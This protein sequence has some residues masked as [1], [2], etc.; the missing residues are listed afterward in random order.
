MALEEGDVE[1]AMGI[2]NT[3]AATG[4]ARAQF[5]YATMLEKGLGGVEKDVVRARHTRTRTHTLT[6]TLV[7]ANDTW[8]LQRHSSP[9]LPHGTAP[10]MPVCIR[11]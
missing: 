8:Q 1:R 11:G 9:A 6:L 3:A 10:V 5:K 4:F 2:F 7:H